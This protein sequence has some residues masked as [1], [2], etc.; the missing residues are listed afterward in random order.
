MGDAVKLRFD[1]IV[2]F[3]FTMSVNVA[4]KRGN[5]VQILLAV[6][7]DEV[8][9]VALADDARLFIHPFLHLGEWMPEVIVIQL[10]KLIVVKRHSLLLVL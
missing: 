8:M 5:A 4:P 10:L 2:E 1:C 9:T 7:I 6:N 3:F